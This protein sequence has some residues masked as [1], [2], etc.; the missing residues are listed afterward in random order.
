MAVCS[1]SKGRGIGEAWCARR[2]LLRL[3]AFNGGA[4]I[5]GRLAIYCWAPYQH[6]GV[7]V[8]GEIV[9][10]ASIQDALH[11]EHVHVRA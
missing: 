10:L 8:D 5:V 9:R 2:L 11:V 3:D 6:Q 1:M 7:G 4:P